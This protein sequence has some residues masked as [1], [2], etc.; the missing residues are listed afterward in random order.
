MAVVMGALAAHGAYDPALFSSL[1][2]IAK[3]SIQGAASTAAAA[4]GSA[5]ASQLSQSAG[6]YSLAE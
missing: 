4:S 5:A 1:T 3:A 6:R 2:S